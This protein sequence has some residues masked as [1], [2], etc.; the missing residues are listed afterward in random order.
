MNSLFEIGENIFD[1]DH[2]VVLKRELTEE[3]FSVEVTE[4]KINS[5]FKYVWAEI[6][7]KKS[8]E[9]LELA[10]AVEVLNTEESFTEKIRLD[11]DYRGIKKSKREEKD[12]KEL[13][14]LKEVLPAHVERKIKKHV[15]IYNEAFKR[16]VESKNRQAWS[17][18]ILDLD[19]KLIFRNNETLLEDD[20]LGQHTKEINDLTDDIGK[21]NEQIAELQEQRKKI[22]ESRQTLVK[23]VLYSLFGNRIKKFPEEYKQMAMEQLDK[24]PNVSPGSNEDLFAF[25]NN[26]T[27]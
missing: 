13:Q 10:N 24:L 18:T 3:D 15:K 27:Q 19:I 12:N 26:Y 5:K 9:M 22:N 11:Y 20:K 25:I 2:Y 8:E 23:K 4:P 21:I 16:A 1:G 14:R 17:D 7:F 6:T